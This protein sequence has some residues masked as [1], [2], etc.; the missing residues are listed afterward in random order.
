[1]AVRDPAEL[2]RLFAERASAGDLEGLVDLYEDGATFVGPDGEHATGVSTIRERLRNLLAAA[3]L[4]APLGH[5]STVMTDD[6]ALFSNR[7][8]MTFG[9]DE[10]APTMNGSS[11]EVARRQSDGSWRYVIDHPRIDGLAAPTIP[12]PTDLEESRIHTLLMFDGR[13]EEAMHFYTQLFP[14][15]E[16]ERIDR[17]QADE[18]GVE[19]T[20]KHA[21]FRLGTHTLT[22]IDSPVKQPFT[23]TPATSLFVDCDSAAAVDRLFAQLSEGGKILMPLDRYPFSQRF[24]WLTDRFGVSWQLNLA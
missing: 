15:S 19:G 13:A 3:P 7:W 6:V 1:M 22:C 14:D 8:Q 2:Y 16:I 18:P 9:S 24:A 21:M 11:T 5:Q 23:F 4:I 12:A 10:S 20:V 17:Y